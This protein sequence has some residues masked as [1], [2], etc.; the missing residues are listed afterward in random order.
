MLPTLR[1]PA[2][3]SPR[4]ALPAWLAADWPLPILC[5]AAAL[6]LLLDLGREPLADWDEAIFA[7]VAREIVQ[8]GDWLTLHWGYELYFNK[9]PLLLWLT[10]CAYL[11][12][13]VTE[14]AARLP[15]ALAGIGLV[16]VTYLTGKVVYDRWAGTLGGLILLASLQ[17]VRFARFGTTDILL[18][19]LIFTSLYAYLR[20]RSGSPHW[21]YLVWGGFGLACM[22]KSA[23][24]LVLPATLAVALWF[25]GGVARAWRSGSFRG[26]AVLAA[27]IVVPW[28]LL[29]LVEYSQEFLR[30]YV[31]HN[32]VERSTQAVEGH[33]GDWLF[34]V[35][36]LQGLFFPWVYVLPFALALSLKENLRAWSRSGPLLVLAVLVFAAYTIIPTKLRW[37]ILPAYPAFVLLL[38]LLLRQASIRLRSLAFAGLAVSCGLV[39][40]M[41][42]PS[43]DLLLAGL[44]ALALVLLLAWRQ[45]ASLLLSGAL[46]AFLFAIG[47]NSVA[48]AYQVSERPLAAAAAAIRSESPSDRAPLILYSGL[49]RPSALFYSERPI[50]QIKNI[51]QLAQLLADGQEHWIVLRRPDL[52]P[53]QQRFDV[54]IVDGRRSV[55]AARIRARA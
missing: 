5:L 4:L 52:K 3:P 42:P 54:S 34:Y 10:A 41:V 45:R 48:T 26:G 11:L 15:S 35:N 8:S 1:R 30:T 2:A 38:A 12:F 53:L 46:A 14:F 33:T 47:A 6:M 32:V 22:V 21:W 20:A 43:L 25:D 28:H 51:G 49:G 39:A 55:I 29:M 27:L 24:A 13:E 17:F 18:T 23:G 50:Q 9:P 16:G 37:Y 31:L 40:L 19:L 7:Q 36:V 44:V